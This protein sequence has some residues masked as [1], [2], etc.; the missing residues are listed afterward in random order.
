[1]VKL[2]RLTA[3]TF[4]SILFFFHSF[5]QTYQQRVNQYIS[6]YKEACHQR[7]DA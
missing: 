2:I 1:M 5:S 4:F 7:N 6:D 3:T